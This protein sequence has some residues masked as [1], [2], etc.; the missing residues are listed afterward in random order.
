MGHLFIVAAALVALLTAG[1]TV[2]STSV[3]SNTG[4]VTADAIMPSGGG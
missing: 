2:N 4:P 3:T 1:V